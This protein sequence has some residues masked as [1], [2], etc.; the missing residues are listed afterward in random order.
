M[1]CGSAALD[2]EQIASAER[3]GREQTKI[4]THLFHEPDGSAI[5]PWH[6]RRQAWEAARVAAGYPQKQ[7]H[8]WRR[9]AAR[10]LERAGVSRS[11][12]MA[13]IGHRT[14][15]MYRRYSIVD[16][17]RMRE[18]VEKL[19]AWADEQRQPKKPAKGSARVRQFRK[20]A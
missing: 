17:A 4:V 8:D 18:E 5:T 19:Q 14:E 7:N 1:T 16:E 11:V 13:M 2:A 6:W 12:A 3:I 9:T 20:R 15:E 10:T